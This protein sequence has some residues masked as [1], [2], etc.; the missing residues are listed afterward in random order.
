MNIY[1]IYAL[2]FITTLLL[3][4]ISY[5]ILMATNVIDI[6]NDR[7]LHLLPRPRG[8]G[9]AIVI[10]FLLIL[11][12]SDLEDQFSANFSSALVYGGIG[13]ALI[14]FADDL[15]SLHP[16]VR[17]SATLCI[18]IFS[19]LSI[20]MP[21]I[22]FMGFSLQPSPLLFLLEVL[23]ILWVLN[24]FNFMDGI[25]AIASL[26]TISVALIAALLLVLL[27]PVSA[28]AY[29]H[30]EA[31]LIIAFSTAGFLIWNWPPAKLFMGDVGSSFLGFTLALFAIQTSIEQISNVWVW[32]ILMG[33]F[34]M[35]A[36]VTI[37]RRILNR[38]KFYQAHRQHAYQ[39][40]VLY[41]QAH[42]TL[43]SEMARAYAHKVVSLIVVAINFLWLAPWAYMAKL[44]SEHGM[45]FALISLTPI[46]VLMILVPRL[47]P[48]Q[49]SEARPPL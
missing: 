41:I 25:D 8:G 21:S 43:T 20:G 46:L 13:I 42:S 47:L 16:I 24:L 35:D 14:G 23:A 18:V 15:Y 12:I 49:K 44:H 28:S 33:V 39:R 30:Q 3:T 48:I 40:L 17:F 45:L 9:I 11:F 34:F 1:I 26:E 32:L 19:V 31:L 29:Y 37:I 5:R 10:T 2:A 36:T 22:S 4:Y 38:E 7:S 6:P 27:P